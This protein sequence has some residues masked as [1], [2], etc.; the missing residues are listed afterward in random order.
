MENSAVEWIENY[1]K[2]FNHIEES[3]SLKKAFQNA[4]KIEEENLI[5]ISV[6]SALHERKWIAEQFSEKIYTPAKIEVIELKSFAKKHYAE[7][8]NKEIKK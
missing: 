8:F 2:K 4:K 6:H 7:L 1:L 5:K 3:L